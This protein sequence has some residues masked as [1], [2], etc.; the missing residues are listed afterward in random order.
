VP[1][2]R[3]LLFFLIASVSTLAW[4]GFEK[5]KDESSTVFLP[6]SMQELARSTQNF[7]FFWKGMILIDAKEKELALSYAQKLCATLNEDTED[8]GDFYCKKNLFRQN[9]EHLRDWIKDIGLRRKAFSQSELEQKSNS[10]LAMASLPGVP[11]Q[12][13]AALRL[14]P[15]AVSQDLWKIK[16]QLFKASSEWEGYFSNEAAD[17]I[18]IPFSFRHPPQDQ[19]RTA[20]FLNKISTLCKSESCPKTAIVGPHVAMLV[21]QERIIDDLWVVSVLGLVFFAVLMFFLGKGRGLALLSLCVPLVPAI[22][23]SMG[24][25]ALIF[26]SIHG[27]TLAFGPSLVGLALDYGLHTK[28]H[29][30]SKP[31]WTSNL[32]GLLTTLVGFVVLLFS[33]IPLIRQMMVFAIIGLLLSFVFYYFLSQSKGR[34]WKSTDF[35]VFSFQMSPHSWQGPFVVLLI[36]ASFACFFIVPLDLNLKN[37]EFRQKDQVDLETR[38]WAGRRPPE[39]LFSISKDEKASHAEYAWSLRTHAT[40]QNWAVYLPQTFEQEENLTDWKSKGCKFSLSESAKKFFKDFAS[41]NPCQ[42]SVRTTSNV[43]AYLSDFVS[44]N[45]DHKELLTVWFPQND[46]DL[47]N[48]NKAYPKLTSIRQIFASF[49]RILLKEIWTM[50]PIGI[51]ICFL[52]IY[53]H[54]R[55][56]THS[57]L[58]LVPMFAAV[59]FVLLF[60]AI[61]GKSLSFVGCIALLMI[62]G[63]SV[64]YGIFQVDC[65]RYEA[66]AKEKSETFSSIFMQALVT[67]IGYLPMV[68][69]KHPVLND[70]GWVLTLGTIGGFLGGVWGVPYLIEK[71]PGVDK[72]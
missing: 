57:L 49:P 12:L 66:S 67:L 71:I 63:S 32:F 59:G 21:N 10:Q 17:V 19:T 5:F 29:R 61:F 36:I 52:I 46:D 62:F 27:L 38:W 47:I 42:N 48:L 58:A 45:L 4:S 7:S 30:G 6:S 1:A 53:Y 24:V 55:K 69:A 37:F 8:V 16:Q 18:M 25:T 33:E 28:I 34:L 43:P 60:F 11:H 22:L 51:L 68:F 20:S 72:A 9:E 70:L 50:F 40:L 54:V 65:L 41:I 23:I 13:I 2:I 14:D 26:G 44:K 64:D 39:L 15:F 56:I 35:K 3:R 31:A